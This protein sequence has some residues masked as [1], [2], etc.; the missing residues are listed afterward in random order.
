MST[1]SPAPIVCYPDPVL[2]KV[3]EPAPAPGPELERLVELLWFT[4]RSTG[5]AGLAAPQIG[6]SRRVAVVDGEAVDHSEERLL[7]IDPI[8]QR[9]EGR[10][11]GDEGCL[12]FPGMYAA[13]TRP[14][15]I[16]VQTSALDGTTRTIS[17]EGLAAR[18]IR[19]EI[20]HLEGVL[21]PDRLG[22]LLRRSFLARYALRRSLSRPLS[23]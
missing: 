20:D 7:L 2:R 6:V 15:R 5:G 3:A 17:A 9:E 8:I 13:V 22:P 4:C 12:S 1:T 14:F 23:T 11:R 19:H 18:A 10:Q 16:D 21:L